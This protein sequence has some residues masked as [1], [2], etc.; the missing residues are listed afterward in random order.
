MINDLAS[1]SKARI[2]D[3][4]GDIAR[5]MPVRELVNSLKSNGKGIS[6][7]VFDGIV[8][9]RILDIAAENKISAIVGTKMGNIAKQP[10][11]VEIWT[12]DDLNE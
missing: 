12:K 4:N 10:V 7:I 9:Q 11:S 3:M 6:A 5:E 2:L 8:T 1:T